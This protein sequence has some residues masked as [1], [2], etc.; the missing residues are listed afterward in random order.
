MVG[1]L[2]NMTLGIILFN[3]ADMLQ[4]QAVVAVLAGMVSYGVSIMLYISAAQIIGATRGQILFSAAPFWGIIGA[5]LLLG[6]PINWTTLAS[7]ESPHG[8]IV[9]PLPATGNDRSPQKPGAWRG[10]G[11]A[12][13]VWKRPLGRSGRSARR[14]SA[15]AHQACAIHPPAERTLRPALRRLGGYVEEVPAARAP[16]QAARRCLGP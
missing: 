12:P 14:R 5:A 3:A 13:A 16:W 6:E 2:V 4:S 8:R 7:R 15:W 1:G 11:S 9:R 10:A